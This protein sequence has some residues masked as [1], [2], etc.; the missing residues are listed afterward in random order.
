MTTTSLN[1]A[2][3]PRPIG[4]PLRRQPIPGC[5]YNLDDFIIGKKKKKKRKCV[6]ELIS[7][8]DTVLL[9]EKK[10]KKYKVNGKIGVWRTIKGRHIFF[11]DDGSGPIPP[12]NF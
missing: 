10:E 2:T 8:G 12:F 7:I 4:K 3:I 6:F 5:V 1:I 11:P 9:E